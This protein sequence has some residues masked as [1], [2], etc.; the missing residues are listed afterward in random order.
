[1]SKYWTSFLPRYTL[2]F[3]SELESDI[4]DPYSVVCTVYLLYLL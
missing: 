2:M 4:I 3:E 1:M